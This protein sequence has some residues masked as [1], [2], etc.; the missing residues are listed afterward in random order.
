MKRPQK[1]PTHPGEILREQFM[2]EFGLSIN[3]VARDL[4]AP[5]TRIAEIFHE[6]RSVTPDTALRPA[7]YFGITPEFWMNLQ[8]AYDLDVA[9]ARSGAIKRD[10]RPVQAA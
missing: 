1:K 3:R 10:V 2:S 4:R 9:R 7:R 5:A 6:R 8:T